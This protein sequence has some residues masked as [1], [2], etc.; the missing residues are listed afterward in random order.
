MAAKCCF[1]AQQFEKSRTVTS[2]TF[3][4]PAPE[5]HKS[6]SIRQRGVAGSTRLR[7]KQIAATQAGQTTSP[8]GRIIAEAMADYNQ[9]A[10][11]HREVF[12]RLG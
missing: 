6:V 4:R 12:K 9:P 8:S 10:R 1:P 5:M 3:E 7:L 11:E 2:G